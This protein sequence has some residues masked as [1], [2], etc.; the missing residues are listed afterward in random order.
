M[1]SPLHRDAVEVLSLLPADGRRDD[2][3]QFLAD[4]PDAMSRECASGHLTASALVVDPDHGAVL[5]MLHRKLGRWL[6]MGG[7]CELSDVS[8]RA[9][10]AREAREESGIRGLNISAMPIN[11]DR[12]ALQCD[13]RHLDHLDVQYLAIAPA[14]APFVA[15]DESLRLQWFAYDDIPR[16]DTAV[17]TLVTAARLQFEGN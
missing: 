15:N 13:G 17:T 7:H 4:H 10:A 6:Q 11:L 5:L 14:A 9:A 12:H 1:T 16:D 2:F 8:V 3:L